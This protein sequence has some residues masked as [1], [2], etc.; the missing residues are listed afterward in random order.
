QPW[1]ELVLEPPRGKTALRFSQYH[2]GLI[3]QPHHDQK[4]VLG[5]C[6]W[7]TVCGQGRPH[8]SAMDGTGACSPRATAQ[9]RRTP[10]VPPR[11]LPER[12]PPA[13]PPDEYLSDRHRPNT[14][15]ACP[16]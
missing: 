12:R 14:L 4:T 9:R 16:N 6:P 11:R 13:V 5:S 7:R 10:T 3:P 1:Y 8:T 2:S 15:R